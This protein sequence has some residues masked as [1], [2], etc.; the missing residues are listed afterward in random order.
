MSTRDFIKTSTHFVLIS[1]TEQ[2]PIPLLTSE[3]VEGTSQR[4]G[5]ILFM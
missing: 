5:N 3:G 1:N 4:D 2:L